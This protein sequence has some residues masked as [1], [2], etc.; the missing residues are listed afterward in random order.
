MPKPRPTLL[1]D[2]AP[3][4]A[5]QAAQASFES[6]RS[7]YKATMLKALRER[8]LSLLKSI[9]KYLVMDHGH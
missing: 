7:E 2:S 4:K 5:R 6:Q 8:R 9:E 3:A 1:P